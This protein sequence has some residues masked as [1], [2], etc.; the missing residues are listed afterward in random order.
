MILLA[1]ATQFDLEIHQ[2]DVKTT[3]LYR[4][5]EENHN[6]DQK[7]WEGVA[8]VVEGVLG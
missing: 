2:F 8:K 4:V 5:L 3:F 6:L 7:E 1:L